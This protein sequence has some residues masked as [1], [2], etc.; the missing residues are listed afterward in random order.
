MIRSNFLEILYVRA[1]SMQFRR[2]VLLHIYLLTTF[3]VC[4]ETDATLELSAMQVKTST[5]KDQITESIKK[6]IKQSIQ[7]S[8]TASSNFEQALLAFTQGNLKEAEQLFLE[9]LQIHPFSYPAR[10]NLAL[11]YYQQKK[12]STALAIWRQ[13]LFEQPFNSVIRQALLHT[14]LQ[15]TNYSVDGWRIKMPWGI[16]PAWLWIPSDIILSIVAI[17][18]CILILFLYYRKYQAISLW[19]VPMI[20]CHICTGY[21][22]S[23]RWDNYATLIE[24]IELKSAPRKQAVTLS[25]H[26]AGQMIKVKQQLQDWV[27]VTAG[28]KTGW[29]LSS[30]L[31]PI[32]KTMNSR[33]LPLYSGKIL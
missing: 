6:P 11:V 25:E 14:Q 10:Y 27:Q 22:F 24:N 13:L 21:Y 4:R 5:T 7:I 18:W 15:S 26:T 1:P 23:F 17:F 33:H 3:L 28:S 31:V 8:S 20:I 29:I 16:I 2:I 9:F 12:L 30:K 19:L 32:K